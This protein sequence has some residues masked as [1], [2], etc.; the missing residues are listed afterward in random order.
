MLDIELIRSNSEG[1]KQNL[2]RRQDPKIV[3]LF[4]VLLKNDLEW[5]HLKQKNDSMRHERNAISQ[6]VNLA[7]NEKREKEA[8]KLISQARVIP[9]QVKEN[10]VRMQKT[11]DKIDSALTVLPNLLHDSVP[12][13][14]SDADNVEV[15]R[16][17]RFADVKRLFELKHHGELAV[18]LGLADFER[19]VK[20]SGTGFYFLKGE[21]ALMDL[22]LQK[23]AI[24]F[25][26]KKGF[27]LVYVPFMMRR[28][29]YEGVAPLAD[30][31]NVMYKVENHDLYLIATSEH[32]MAAM[33]MDEILDEGQLP[34]KLCGISSCFRVEI[35]KHG[36]D[37][38]GL[39]RVHQFNKVEQF[40]FCLPE[41]SWKIHEELLANSEALLQCLELPY[42]VVNVC[43]GEIGPIASKKYDVEAYSPREDK[44]IEVMSCSNCTDY[45]SNSLGI[46]YRKKNSMEKAPVHTLNNTA[47]ATARI[48]R[49]ILEHYQTKDGTVKVPKALQPYMNGLK[50]IKA[51]K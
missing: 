48:L 7:K 25:L 5:R 3:S 27:T 46:R 8:A 30:F 14:S 36:L 47:I 19:A 12:G 38:K 35:G 42:R 50:E 31:E 18:S 11:R 51:K 10:E 43:A 49:L 1:V 32:P 41:Q 6:K 29:P 9:G 45:Q 16:W 4:A 28:K 22:A 23:L 34:V 33:Y 37:E 2:K 40:V 20:I 21:L 24:D 44:F 15:K 26:S 13:G 17:G 39:F